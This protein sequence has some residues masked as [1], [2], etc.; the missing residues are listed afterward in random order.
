MTASNNQ[1]LPRWNV[2]DVHESLDARSFTDAL[3]LVGA[4]VERLAVLFDELD[5]RSTERS[6]EQADG[7]KADRAIAEFKPGV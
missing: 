1:A 7:D 5:I 6:I 4:D 3:E 2:T